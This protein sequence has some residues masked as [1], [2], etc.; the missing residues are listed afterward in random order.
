MMPRSEQVGEAVEECASSQTADGSESERPML[1]SD[2][3]GEEEALCHRLCSLPPQRSGGAGSIEYHELMQAKGACPGPDTV[4]KLAGWLS[5]QVKDL[6]IGEQGSLRLH[7]LL[8]ILQ[9][10]YVLHSDY[11]GMLTVEM[12]LTM[13]GSVLQEYDA[14][15]P[16]SWLLVWRTCDRN[17]ASQEL[18]IASE[19]VHAFPSFI[20]RVHPIHAENIQAMR[21]SKAARPKEARQAYARIGNYIRSSN[22]ALFGRTKVTTSPMTHGG[23]P[24]FFAMMSP[25]WMTTQEATM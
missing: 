25:T 14:D 3:D 21:P 4:A 16:K 5:D 19:A 6:A 12:C 8:S 20:S 15:Y 24:K 7:R 2:D 11:S 1:T 13:L 22:S 23:A 17:V 9:A 10:G 18:A